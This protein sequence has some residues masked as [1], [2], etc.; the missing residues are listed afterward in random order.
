MIMFCSMVNGLAFCQLTIN[1]Y[2]GY[3]HENLLNELL[4]LLDYFDKVYVI[5]GYI[6]F[7]RCQITAVMERFI[8]KQFICIILFV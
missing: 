5:V 7:Y 8:I 6:C 4:E 2:M 1:A 3:F